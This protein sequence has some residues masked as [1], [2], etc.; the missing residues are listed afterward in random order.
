MKKIDLVGKDIRLF[1]DKDLD[2]AIAASLI[3][4]YS[5]ANIV[6][7]IPAHAHFMKP[8]KIEG[9]LDVFVDCRSAHRDEDIRIDHHQS[10]ETKKYLDKSG[11]LVDAS[12]DSAVS[13][14]ADFLGIKVNKRIL[15][16][17]D[18]ADSGRSNAFS[19]FKLGDK[20]FH[21]ILIKP[22]ILKEDF[23]NFEIF[24][25][26]LLGFME[27]GFA[28]EDLK[29]LTKYEQMLEVKYGVIIEE[30]KKSPDAPLVKLIHSPIRESI[31][32]EKI[33][34][35][36]SSNFFGNVLPYVNQHYEVEAAKS[37]LGIYVV[38]GFRRYNEKYDHQLIKIYSDNHRE[39]YQIYVDR[40]ASNTTI[41]I[42]DLINKAKKYAQISNGGGRSDVGGLNSSS[43][44]KAIKALRYIIREIKNRVA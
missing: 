30:I 3:I 18:K 16:E 44:K 36:T 7:M 33:F 27:K 25:D 38:V 12:Y 20:T 39:P 41:D 31:F 1:F 43:K 24:K 4:H 23:K 17:M 21:H 10:G 9:V 19:K 14:V 26:K 13:L 8:D 40:S 42:G 15:S 6:K 37:N 35:I 28:V 34:K 11:I 22:G 5:G 29:S 32:R 2:G